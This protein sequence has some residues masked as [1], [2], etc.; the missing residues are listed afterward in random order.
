MTKLKPYIP[1]VRETDIL[2]RT[3]PIVV[4]LYP[5]Y[6]SIRIKGR[7][8]EFTVDYAE[9]FDLA[10]KITYRRNAGKSA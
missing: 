1:L 10:R 5:R 7:R 6:M 8:E 4:E 2:E 9:I 3:D